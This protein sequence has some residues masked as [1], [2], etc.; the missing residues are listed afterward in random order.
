MKVLAICHEDPEWI[1]GGMGMH[2]RELYRFMA[3]RGVEVDFLTSGPGEGAQPFNGF[4]KWQS[5]KHV[6]F[7]PHAANMTSILLQDLQL[8][9]TLAKLLAQGKRW[10][11]VHMHEW[12]SVQLGRMAARALDVPLIGT[13][14]L[15][16]TKLAE[17]ENP[18]CYDDI[19]D[20]PE[21]EF[22]LRQQEANLI[23]DPDEFILCSQSYIGMVRETFMTQRPINLIYNGIDPEIWFPCEG[24]LP[25]RPYAD[26][27][28]ALYV[29]RIATMKGIVPLLDS[30][31]R[32]DNGWHVRLA[33]EVNANTAE[34]A[35]AWEVTQRIKRLQKEH[36]ER[37]RWL[38]FRSGQDLRDEYSGA[39]CVVMP[40][41]HEPFGIVAL[42]AMAM[43]VPLLC[44]EV[45]G[46]GEIVV[47]EHGN[48]S[49]LIIPAGS[50]DAIAAG[51]EMMRDPGARLELRARGLKRVRDFTWSEAVTKT[52]QVYHRAIGSRMREAI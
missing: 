10:D 16:I 29:G 1:L 40:S 52:L 49:A 34:E 44:T 17:V 36:P 35:D 12:G 28:V 45:D 6:C 4:T 25:T 23:G 48:E 42:E 27:L 7:K 9:K 24:P 21:V 33:G 31:E 26:R 14:H 2:C 20:W 32:E 22:Y 47:D 38:G 19:K 8:A 43:G 5:E 39:D 41:I 37:L 46:L 30:I 15:C 50:A 11:V 18:S 13:M 3:K 51:L